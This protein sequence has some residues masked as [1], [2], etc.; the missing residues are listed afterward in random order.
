MENVGIDMELS[1]AEVVGIFVLFNEILYRSSVE[2]QSFISFC[3]LQ[4]SAV[5]GLTKFR[6]SMRPLSIVL[7]TRNFHF[8]LQKLGK[9]GQRGYNAG[10]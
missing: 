6:D 10:N 8:K 5:I 4:L 9:N 7:M 3:N 2:S 1:V